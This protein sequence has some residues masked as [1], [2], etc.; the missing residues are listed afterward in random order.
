MILIL[1]LA[2]DPG[3]HLLSQESASNDMITSMKLFF[4]RHGQTDA[5][6]RMVGGQFI[7]ELDEPLNQIGIE[8]ANELAEQLKDMEFDAIISSPLKRA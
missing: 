8:Q 2:H 4:V 5:N 1:A 6:A 7:Q 3:S